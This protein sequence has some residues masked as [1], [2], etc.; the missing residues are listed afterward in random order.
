MACLSYLFY[1]S[2]LVGFNGERGQRIG[3]PAGDELRA[4]AVTV[5]AEEGGDVFLCGAGADAEVPG[6]LAVANFQM[7]Q[8]RGVSRGL[9]NQFLRGKV[10]A[11]HRCS[12]RLV[13]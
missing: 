8:V 5:G 7:K 4:A 13:D 11:H 6:D 3:N 12:K 2:C 10:L 9:R 1:L